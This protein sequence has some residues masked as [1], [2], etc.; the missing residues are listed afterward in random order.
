ML[1]KNS[2][3]VHIPAVATVV[4]DI[5]ARAL[6]SISGRIFLKVLADSNAPPPDTGKLK[7]GGVPQSGGRTQRGGQGSHVGDQGP[8]G[9]GQGNGPDYNL[10]PMVGI[11]LSAGYGIAIS[12]ENGNFLLRDLPAGDLAISLI[13]VKPVP[14][15]MKVPSGMVRMPPEP[16]E[17]QGATIIISNPDLV[18]YLVGKTAD[19][20]RDAAMHPPFPTSKP[21]KLSPPTSNA[22]SSKEAGTAEGSPSRKVPEP[23]HS[24][25]AVA[26]PTAVS[27]A[28]AEAAIPSVSPAGPSM[29]VTKDP[30]ESETAMSPALTAVSS[31][32]KSPV[33]F[34]NSDFDHS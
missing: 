12:D 4:Q 11:Q 25:P 15:D 16:I 33:T 8:G 27:P 24:S 13:P 28:A 3:V 34:I 26:A 20:V 29:S 1:P 21:A 14:P 31:G 2:Y 10:V 6:R 7:I 30:S 19:E 18:P 23:I 17:V 9:Q 22:E 5:P 32:G